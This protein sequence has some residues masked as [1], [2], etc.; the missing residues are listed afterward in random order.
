M[1]ELE[2]YIEVWSGNLKGRDSLKSV[3]ESERRSIRELGV[4]VMSH[5]QL[6]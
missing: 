6:P 3:R 1:E 2:N 5:Y 4:D